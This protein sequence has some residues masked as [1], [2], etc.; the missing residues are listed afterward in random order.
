MKYIV[1]LMFVLFSASV[2]SWDYSN[3]PY[4]QYGNPNYRYEGI[5]GQRYQYDLSDPGDQI[6]YG[7]DLDAQMR[8][9]INPSPTIDLDRGINNYGG[10]AEW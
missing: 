9:Q 2:L 6:E 7:L 5:S 4:D 3:E 1:A 10:G 8:D